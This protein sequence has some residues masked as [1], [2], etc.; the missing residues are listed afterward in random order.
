MKIRKAFS[1]ISSKITQFNSLLVEEIYSLVSLRVYHYYENIRIQ[2]A[3]AN[4]RARLDAGRRR[5][6]SERQTTEVEGHKFRKIVS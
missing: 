6:L 2:R 5:F 3:A 1:S 4:E